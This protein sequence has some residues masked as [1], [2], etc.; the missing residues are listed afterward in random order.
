MNFD[1]R[2]LWAV[3]S[4]ASHIGKNLSE[5]VELYLQEAWRRGWL[6]NDV[7]VIAERWPESEG[8]YVDKWLL[9][10][11]ELVIRVYLGHRLHDKFTPS[12]PYYIGP[13]HDNW[14]DDVFTTFAPRSSLH[15]SRIPVAFK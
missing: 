8:Y 1:E 13:R 11:G 7:E 6:T 2:K 4:N 3:A 14:S 10:R 5:E 15:W 9:E 12:R